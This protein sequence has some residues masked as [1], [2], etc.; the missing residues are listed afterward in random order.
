M[1]SIRFHLNGQTI[2]F[3]PQ[4]QKSQP[5]LQDSI[6]HAKSEGTE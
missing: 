6:I 1:L 3:H 4:T 5:T 2:G